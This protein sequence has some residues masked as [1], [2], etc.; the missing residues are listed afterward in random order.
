MR[1]FVAVEVPGSIRKGLATLQARLRGSG[2]DVKWVRPESVHLT[3]KFLGEI[4]GGAVADIREALREVIH[5]HEPF[6]VRVGGVGCFPRL[7][8]PRVVWVGLSGDDGRLISLQRE[9]E[10]AM[11]ALGFQREERGFRPHLTLGRVRSPKARERLVG[12][13]QALQEADVGEFQV[14]SVVLFQS[15][16]H[17]S[18]ARYTPLWEAVLGREGEGAEG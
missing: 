2:A 1:S 7:N 8:Q 4:E 5:R 10:S 3:L 18:G 15:E 12:L 17:P 14:R 16:L 13:V 6:S 11:E 9:V